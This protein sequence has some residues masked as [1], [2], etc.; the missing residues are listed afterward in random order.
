MGSYIYS[1]QSEVVEATESLAGLKLFINVYKYETKPY[2]EIWTYGPSPFDA[3]E[4][5]VGVVYDR[6]RRN[7]ATRFETLVR[8]KKCSHFVVVGDWRKSEQPVTVYQ[9]E[10]P[11]SLMV[12]DEWHGVKGKRVGTLAKAGRGWR[13]TP[14]TLPMLLPSGSAEAGWS[15][16]WC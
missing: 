12:D 13:F 8:N 1:R 2:W 6:I 7:A 3:W 14:D 16:R 10:Q 15:W 9:E 5:K 4:R 11:Q